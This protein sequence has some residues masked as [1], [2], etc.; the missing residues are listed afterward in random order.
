MRRGFMLVTPVL[1]AEHCRYTPSDMDA[2]CDL[3]SKYL[4][5]ESRACLSITT[6][7]RTP[8]SMVHRLSALCEQA[9]F[10]GPKA[11]L[12]VAAPG[13]AD[14]PYAILLSLSDAIVVSGDSVMMSTEACSSGV[15][16]FVAFREKC[17]GKLEA[18]H[19]DLAARGYTC[20]LVEREDLD[21]RW[22][23]NPLDQV[24]A[25]A[26]ELRQSLR[27]PSEMDNALSGT[28]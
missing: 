13:R 22:D 1:F 8:T 26:D 18:F 16:V 4:A 23:Y 2:L 12:Y 10:A 15:P 19:S 24:A 21:L 14:N 20:P 25:V 6:S 17:R 9:N 27:I 3:L 7:R 11:H 28:S 5:R